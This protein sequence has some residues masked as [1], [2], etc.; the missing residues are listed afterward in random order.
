MNIEITGCSNCPFNFTYWDETK[1]YN[2][3]ALAQNNNANYIN[4]EGCKV[5]PKNCPLPKEGIT[6]KPVK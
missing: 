3:C 4:T 6:I 5:F 1:Q 2:E